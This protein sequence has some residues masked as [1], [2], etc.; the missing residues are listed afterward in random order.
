LKIFK[1]FDLTSYNSYRIKANCKVAYFPESVDDVIAFY[2]MKLPYVLLGSGHNIIFSKTYYNE[3]F[4]IFNG[5][6]NRVNTNENIIEAEAGA[7][8]LQ[9]SKNALN[10]SLTGAEFL[11]D[12]PSSVG[13][14]VV[15]NAGTK[16]GETKNIL[17]NVL[18]L[19]LN[20]M[21]V[22]EKNKEEINFE[23]R[24]SFFQKNKDKVILKAWFEL[25]HGNALLIKKT[26]E[27][28]KERRWARQPKEFPNAGSVFKRPKGFYVGAM[29]DELNLK[30]FTIG[31]AKI[32]EKH[33][34]FIINHNNA[35]GQDII[36]IIKEVKK[37]VMD[38]FNV[39][40]QIEQRII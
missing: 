16:E 35:T 4:L 21:M 25:K 12:I 30:G 38:R 1:N 6:F 23:Y 26:M 36:D 13:G 15:M 28:S 17:R 34:G 5:N 9:V 8:I 27:D 10:N 19:D 29:I 7:T 32:S 22:K 3:N 14:A 20:D 24:N 11:Y 33:G 2:A 31:G 37:G 18:Y 40:L 39:D